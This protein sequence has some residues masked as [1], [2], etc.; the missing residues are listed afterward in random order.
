MA[1]RDQQ[2]LATLLKLA[3]LREQRAARAL[4]EINGQLQAA[5]RQVGQL[6]EYQ[7]EYAARLRSEASSGISPVTLRNY[8]RFCN[9][10]NGARDQQL[11]SVSEIEGRLDQVR[12]HWNQRYARRRLLEQLRDRRRAAAERLAEQRL[13]R[14]F[15]DRQASLPS[16]TAFASD[17]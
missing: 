13:Q 7:L 9:A 4:G 15:D 1:R 12:E 17:V 11:R 10:L 6:S 5:H 8:D 16:H 3:E 14:E 2:R